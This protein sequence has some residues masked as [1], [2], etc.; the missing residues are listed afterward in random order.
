MRLDT[1][2]RV[3]LGDESFRF[4]WLARER[5]HGQKNGPR[6]D[7]H[8][9]GV[10][11]EATTT[12]ACLCRGARSVRLRLGCLSPWQ[13]VSDAMHGA[14]DGDFEQLMDDRRNRCGNPKK[15]DD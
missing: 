1:L 7:Q 2:V 9:L 14:R 3:P 11:A 4:H 12:T 8:I 13:T 10:C 15:D 6:V 5:F